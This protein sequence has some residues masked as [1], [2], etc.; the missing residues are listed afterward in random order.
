MKKQKNYKF[1]FV[2]VCYDLYGDEH[3]EKLKWHS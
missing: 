3:A 2:Q 1:G